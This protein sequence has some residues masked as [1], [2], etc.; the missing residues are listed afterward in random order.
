[1]IRLCAWCGRYLGDTDPLGDPRPTHGICRGCEKRT[2]I[3]PNWPGFLVD[4]EK[5]CEDIIER[6]K[7]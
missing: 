4:L 1:M 7:T 2:S 3:D 5:V 6:R